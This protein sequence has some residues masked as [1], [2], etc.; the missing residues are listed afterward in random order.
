MVVQ[1][2]KWIAQKFKIRQN[3]VHFAP[4]YSIGINIILPIGRLNLRRGEH[5]VKLFNLGIWDCYTFDII[6]FFDTFSSCHPPG[7]IGAPSLPLQQKGESVDSPLQLQSSTNY[8][9]PKTMR[10]RTC[11]FAVPAATD[12]AFFT[13]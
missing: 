1:S 10:L 12:S 13:L 5:S 2:K 8:S 9:L 7:R 11:L 3:V 6:I 4:P